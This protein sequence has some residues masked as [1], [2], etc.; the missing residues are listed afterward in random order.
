MK[1]EVLF[2]Q[3]GWPLE[4]ESAIKTFLKLRSEMQQRLYVLGIIMGIKKE[5]EQHLEPLLEAFRQDSRTRDFVR[6]LELEKPFEK[7]NPRQG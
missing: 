6:A 7:P 3:F 2:E 1:T 5:G 4:P